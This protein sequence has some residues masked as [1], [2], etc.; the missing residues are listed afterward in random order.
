[1]SNIEKKDRIGNYQFIKTIGEGTFGKVKLSIHLPTKE[2][3]AIKILEKSRINDEEELERVQK[4]IK[5]LKI[6][7]HPNIIQIYEVIENEK[8]FYIV[9]EYV[10]GGEL[11]HYI[12]DHQ[13]LSEKES[14]FF[15]AQLI[16]GIKEIHRNKICHRDIKPEN[17]LLT[18]K[19]IIKIIDFGLSN[20]YIDVLDSQCGSPCY[21]AP[22]MIRGMNYDGLMVDLWACG[23]IL[24]AMLCGYLP[25]DDKDNIIVFRKI[26]QCKLEFPSEDETI[27]SNDAKDLIIRI[28]TPNPLNRIKIEEILRHPFLKSGIQEYRNM[29]PTIFNQEKIIIDYMVNKLKYNNKDNLITKLVKANKHNG[30]TTTY[31]LLQKKI[32]EGRFNYDYNKRDSSISPIKYMK[33][34]ININKNEDK[35]NIENK[36]TNINNNN[37]LFTKKNQQKNIITSLR[38]SIKLNNNILDNNKINR[39]RSTDSTKNSTIKDLN[40]TKEN[41]EK[42]YLQDN[43]LFGLKNNKLLMEDSI[44]KKALYQELISK[45][46]NI[47]NFKREID[48]SVSREKKQKNAPKKIIS[49]TPVK[50]MTNPFVYEQDT[51]KNNYNRRKNIIQKFIVNKRNGISADKVKEKKKIRYTPIHAGRNYLNRIKD[52]NIKL[53]NLRN[54]YV[55]SPFSQFKTITNYELSADRAGN[56]ITKRLKN[57]HIKNNKYNYSKNTYNNNNNF[58][59]KKKYEYNNNNITVISSNN[60]SNISND[61]HYKKKL[62]NVID[63]KY[64]NILIINKNIEKAKTPINSLKYNMIYSNK[65]NQCKKMPCYNPVKT[66]YNTIE[67][68]EINNKNYEIK[69]NND[70]NSKVNN[71]VNAKIIYNNYIYPQN[72]NYNYNYNTIKTEP[73]SKY[74]INNNRIKKNINDTKYIPLALKTKKNPYHEKVK[75]MNITAENIYYNNNNILLNKNVNNNRINHFYTNANS[76]LTSKQ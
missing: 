71:I 66:N 50:Y 14:S 6:L 29:S 36:F 70:K 35:N 8:A 15:F 44:K 18:E 53:E 19:K 61:I 11:F 12:L 69:D 46:K 5:Y 51:I 59:N 22:E 20:E 48:T 13:K 9:M 41:K 23:I 16:Y 34:K 74:I 47:N 72:N 67:V 24:Y 28:L 62:N 10:S 75:T 52:L 43:A 55:F 30:Y 56:N 42:K 65:T 25:F 73:K 26:L 32:I 38:K 54:Q 33:I 58:L 1:M 60:N 17:L 39:P 27:L 31:K 64:R 40:I 49:K 63:N 37:I 68:T 76:N 2:Y 7:N 57:N 4:E 21:A 45:N 3:V